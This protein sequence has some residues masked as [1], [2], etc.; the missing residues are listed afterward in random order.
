MLHRLV[1]STFSFLTLATCQTTQNSAKNEKVDHSTT[2]KTDTKSS[3][4]VSTSAT[5]TTTP[6]TAE[7]KMSVGLPPDAD[8]VKEAEKINANKTGIVY[9]KEGENKF[10]KEYQMNVTFKQMSEDSL[11]PKDVNCIWAGVATADVEFMGLATRPMT[12]QISTINDA[13]KGY[14]KTQSFNGYNIS[15]VSV[16]PETTSEKGF[17]ALKGTYQIGLKFEQGDPVNT[18][19]QRGGT[20]TK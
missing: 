15:L 10:V 19:V 6:K 17:K 5:G 13:N 3:T 1:L 2:V 4:N 16:T 14:T 20:T 9:L 8:A 7:P 12:L 18:T 11:C